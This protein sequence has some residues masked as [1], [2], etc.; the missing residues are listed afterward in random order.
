MCS[1]LA[2]HTRHEVIKDVEITFTCR[3]CLRDSGSLK[4]VFYGFETVESTSVV[5]LELGVV[6][7]SRGIVVGEC[8]RVP[9]GFEDELRE[10]Q[11]GLV[12]G[13]QSAHL[14]IDDLSSHFR[15]FLS[16]R[17]DADL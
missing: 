17:S 5:E 13:K 2:R 10:A 7:V 3:R 8:V 16:R 1:F 15:A 14:C 6:A 4:V 11:V 9:K 12:S